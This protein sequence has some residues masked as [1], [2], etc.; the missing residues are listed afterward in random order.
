MVA[1]INESNDALS[2]LLKY[3]AIDIGAVD[4]KRMTA[5]ELAINYKN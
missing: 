1:I 5:Y 2:T 3:G 4:S